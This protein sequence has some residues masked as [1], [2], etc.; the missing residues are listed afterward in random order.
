MTTPLLTDTQV[1]RITAWAVSPVVI[2]EPPAVPPWPHNLTLPETQSARTFDV[3]AL[4]ALVAMTCLSCVA[5]VAI[6]GY[7]ALAMLAIVARG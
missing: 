5:T 7:A 3:L 6:V 1:Q 4:A 2:V